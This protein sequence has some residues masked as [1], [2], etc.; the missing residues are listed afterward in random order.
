MRQSGRFTSP[1]KIAYEEKRDL[2]NKIASLRHSFE[3]VSKENEK[4]KTNI[5]SMERNYE[6]R[7]E[8]MRQDLSFIVEQK[9]KKTSE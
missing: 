3:L 4:L 2:L 1:K 6:E 8:K 5:R 9:E 7:I